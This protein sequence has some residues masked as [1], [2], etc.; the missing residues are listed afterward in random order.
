MSLT[1][2]THVQVDT[3]HGKVWSKAWTTSVDGLVVV[4]DADHD[5]WS[6]THRASGKAVVELQGRMVNALRV[7]A[8][9]LRDYDWM[10]PE[11]DLTG[12]QIKAMV[13]SVASALQAAMDNAK[14]IEPDVTPATERGVGSV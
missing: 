8:H 12:E 10:L 7:A 11:G 3:T 2:D 14:G 5:R 6:L 9:Q 1:Q 4:H 13:L